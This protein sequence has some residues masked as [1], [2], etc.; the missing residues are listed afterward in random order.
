MILSTLACTIYELVL[1]IK[2]QVLTVQPHV[3]IKTA[4]QFVLDSIQ[5]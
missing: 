5:L 4:L 3:S 2:Q 1:L